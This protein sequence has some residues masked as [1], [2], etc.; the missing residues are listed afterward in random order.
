M[1][2]KQDSQRCFSV[3]FSQSLR[4]SISYKHLKTVPS[5]IMSMKAR[6]LCGLHKL[7]LSINKKTVQ[8]GICIGG[9]KLC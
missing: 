3:K 8:N 5:K 1:L 6:K 2:L 4:K 7:I 9:K